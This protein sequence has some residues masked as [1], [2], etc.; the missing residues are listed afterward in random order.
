MNTVFYQ[1]ENAIFEVSQ[2]DVEDHIELLKKEQEIEEPSKLSVVLDLIAAGKGSVTC[3]VCGKQYRATE[4][5]PVTV[6]HGKTPFDVKIRMKGGV[7][8]FF[9]KKR[10]M[11]LYGG[12]AYECP[13]NHQLIS[14]ITWRT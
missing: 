12:T 9:L 13:A 3:K 10:R 7:K 11:P 6:G 8:G 5:K 1:S 2:N 14:A 4:L